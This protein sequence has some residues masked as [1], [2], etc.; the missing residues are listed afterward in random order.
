MVALCQSMA[1]VAYLSLNASET[2][3]KKPTHEMLEAQV[4]LL[5]ECLTTCNE[6]LRS[7]MSIAERNGSATNWNGHREQ[8]RHALEIHHAAMNSFPN[9]DRMRTWTSWDNG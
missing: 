1:P 7:A 9:L 8:L 3:M 5:Y 6:A 2:H 4:T